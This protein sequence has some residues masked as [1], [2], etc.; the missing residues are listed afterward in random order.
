M[1]QRNTL[2][3]S[4]RY[5]IVAVGLAA[6][7][8]GIAW[9]TASAATVLSYDG[10]LQGDARGG[11]PYT[12]GSLFEV[13]DTPRFVTHLGAQDA[14]AAVDAQDPDGADGL[15]GYA[16]DDGFFNEGNGIQ[17]GLWSADGSTLLASALVT[18]SDMEIGSWRYAPIPGGPVVLEPN[19]QY[20]IGAFVGGGI[21]WFIDNDTSTAP[22]DADTGFTLI[23]NRFLSGS[24]GAPVNDGGPAVGRWGPANAAAITAVPIPEPATLAALGLAL[25]G[26]RRYVK[27]RKA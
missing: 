2:S 25:V 23:G 12:V 5:Y 16:D 9:N 13:G 24:F 11:G 1:R 15:T 26:I 27:R 3:R 4:A 14:D 20:L 10:S 18:S 21:E 17:V 19:T 7:V 22:F 6:L 8:T